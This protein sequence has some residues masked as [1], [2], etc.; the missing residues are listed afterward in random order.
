MRSLSIR[1]KRPKQAQKIGPAY[2]M[3]YPAK[4]YR[5]ATVY[6]WKSSR[7]KSPECYGAN[8]AIEASNIIRS[9]VEK[10][11]AHQAKIDER[12]MAR[13]ERDKTA[14]DQMAEQCQVGSI[15]VSMWGYE[16]TNIDFY[17][18]VRRPSEK[19]VILRE[20]CQYAEEEGWCRTKVK[21]KAGEY[22]GPEFRRLIT[23]CGIKI[24][25]VCRA[26]P[27]DWDREYHATSYA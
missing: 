17:E 20:L 9:C 11:E 15:L 25:N 10:A 8:D 2:V 26:Y 18:V 14:K 22:A 7:A 23:P 6:V 13:K 19:A 4:P 21:P 24:D 27:I 12:K 1:T 5:Y 16:Q 3:I